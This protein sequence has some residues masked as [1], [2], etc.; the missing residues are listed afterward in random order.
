MEVGGYTG[1]SP[2]RR[3]NHLDEVSSP[4]RPK[5]SYQ[6]HHVLKHKAQSVPSKEPALLEAETLDKLLVEAIKDVLEEQGLKENIYDPQIESL[7]LEAFRNAVEEC[8][9]NKTREHSVL[10]DRHRHCERLLESPQ[11]HDHRTSN[12]THSHRL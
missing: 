3:L 2:K 7:A 10:T 12:R 9:N 5:R 6:R 11:V 1:E 4:K 8:M